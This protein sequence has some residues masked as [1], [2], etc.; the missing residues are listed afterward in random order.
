MKIKRMTATFGCLDHQTLEL[1]D[2]LDI[3]TL[4]NAR[5]Q[6]HLCAFLRVM[7]Y[8]LSTPGSGTKK[9]FLSDK[10]H[11][12]SPGTAGSHGGDALHLAGQDILIRRYT[13]GFRSPW[14]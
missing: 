7:L 2:G 1:E 6:I 10:T 8:G 9:G 12:I 13:K 4:P 14:F 3:L 11:G 5:G